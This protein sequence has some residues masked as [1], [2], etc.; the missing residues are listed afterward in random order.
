MGSLETPTSDTRQV[1]IFDESGF[2]LICFFSRSPKAKAFRKWA[3]EVLRQVGRQGFYISSDLSHQL[4]HLQS[5]IHE[6][7]QLLKTLEQKHLKR[8]GEMVICPHCQQIQLWRPRGGTYR[9]KYCS[10]PACKLHFRIQ[11]EDQTQMVSHLCLDR[12]LNYLQLLRN[13]RVI[14]K[15]LYNNGDLQTYSQKEL[16]SLV[17]VHCSTIC[18][19]VDR[20]TKLEI[21][22]AHTND[23]VRKYQIHPKIL[24][25]RDWN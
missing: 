21:L 17:G 14:F 5:Q 23:P 19:I 11:E 20:L 2:I 4:N 6:N 15:T 9:H 12:F 16:A 13:E 24:T 7:R 1:R 3:I 18:R 8:T 25:L 10:N 22:S